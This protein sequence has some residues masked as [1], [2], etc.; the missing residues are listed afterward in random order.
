MSDEIVCFAEIFS[1]SGYVT[2]MEIPPVMGT[3]VAEGYGYTGGEILPNSGHLLVSVE[4]NQARIDYV[5]AYHEENP[6]EVWQD[7]EGELW[8]SSDQDME[9]EIS[10]FTLSGMLV[11]KHQSI[12]MQSKKGFLL[13]LQIQS[14]LYLLNL[15]ADGFSGTFKVIL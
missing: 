8:I 13:S 3:Q 11:Y 7:E 6:F 2:W 9:V 10:L 14:G 1:A 4:N 5:R 15:R 12:I